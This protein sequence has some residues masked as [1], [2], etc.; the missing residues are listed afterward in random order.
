MTVSSRFMLAQRHNFADLGAV[1]AR[2]LFRKRPWRGPRSA[3]QDGPVDLPGRR[4]TVL[5]PP[6]PDALVDAYVNHLGVDRARYRGTVPPHL[7]PQWSLGA[8]VRGLAGLDLPLSR[9][10]N[11]GCQM[12]TY[13]AIPR[14][15]ALTVDAQLVAVKAQKRSLMLVQRVSTR[16]PNGET[17][18]DALCQWAIP[19]RALTDDARAKWTRA[20]TDH[21]DGLI[22]IGDGSPR[23]TDAPM[24]TWHLTDESA[25][26][27]AVLTGDINP[28]HW[29]P[30]AA[31]KAGFAHIILHGFATFART[32]EALVDGGYG[33]PE[34]RVGTLA[35]VF[36]RPLV[37]PAR[38]AV[39]V[40]EAQHVWVSDRDDTTPYL[41]GRFRPAPQPR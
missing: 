34:A 3:S 20:A 17:P 40:D 21:V 12:S 16:L 13:G 29:W 28:I 5:R 11:G 4:T 25:Q 2:A 8:V 1:G 6:L 18:V 19:Y 36:K 37:L 10:L 35:A 14:G 39:W 41:R 9:A 30:T 24:Q 26:Q 7:F 33:G 31:R 32:Y 38:P 23:G 22:A 15:V 27:F